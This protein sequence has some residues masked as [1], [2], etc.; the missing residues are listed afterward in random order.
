MNLK[1]IQSIARRKLSLTGE[2]EFVQRSGPQGRILETSI[3]KPDSDKL[4]HVVIYSNAETVD[5]ADVYHEMSRAKLYELGFRSIEDAALTFLKECSGD[6]P[7]HI[8]DANSAIVIV[9]EAYVSF[10]LYSYFPE[11]SEKRRLEIVSR[12]ESHDALTNLHT[13]MGFWGTAGIAYYKLAAEWAGK[14]FATKRVE[15]AISRASDGKSISEELSKI[16]AALSNLPKIQV[17]PKEFS[18][19]EKVQVLAIIV[20]LF[21]AKTGIKCN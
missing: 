10:L 21:S 17:P 18:E 12:F 7:K 6:D 16:E 8:F 13:Q 2:I 4:K 14:T 19:L 11:E 15:A 1:K 9:A 5:P 3:V 20:E